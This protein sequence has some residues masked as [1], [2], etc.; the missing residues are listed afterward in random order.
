[1]KLYTQITDDDRLTTHTEHGNLFAYVKPGQ[2]LRAAASAAWRI[3]HAQA[4][5]GN[6]LAVLTP[7]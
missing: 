7:A 5:D 6:L 1:M 4:K 2:E 3:N